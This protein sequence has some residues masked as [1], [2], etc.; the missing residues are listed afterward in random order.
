[1]YYWRTEGHK[2]KLSKRC[3]VIA[4]LSLAALS[5]TAFFKAPE[6]GNKVPVPFRGY[7]TETN[8]L[9]RGNPGV[10]EVALTFDDGPR[11][12]YLLR[13]LD[14]L[15]RYEVK[16]TFFV[17]GS[18]V[19]AEPHLIKEIHDR[20]HIVANHTMNHLILPELTDFEI[21]REI[22]DCEALIQNATGEERYLLFRAPG[23]HHENRVV[24]IAQSMGYIS[25]DADAT[26]KDFTGSPGG[27]IF[28][29]VAQKVEP[30]TVILL[31]MTDPT[32]EAL[33]TIIEYTRAKGYRFVTVPE[34]LVHLPNPVYADTTID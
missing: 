17:V 1:M 9:L 30:G 34:M 12:K 26:A 19:E 23:L 22:L 24:E 4:A 3:G 8:T 20:G 10:H 18:R 32:I 28:E 5:V 29:F 25:V 33:P 13:V 2:P 16:A 21:A 11:E 14:I 27:D 15:D 7:V 31:H 6:I